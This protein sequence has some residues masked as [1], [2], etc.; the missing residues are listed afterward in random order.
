MPGNKKP[1]KK[2]RPK[3]NLQDPVGYLLEGLQ[4]I[5][6]KDSLL[7]DLQ[8]KNSAAMAAL[9]RGRANRKDMDILI[10]MSNMIDAL[11]GFG[12]GADY[13]EV[14]ISGRE[15]LIT[16]AHRSQ[17]VGKFGPSG[18]DIAALNALLE[19]HDAQMDVITVNDMQRAISQINTRLARGEATHLPGIT[20]GEIHV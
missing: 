15:A 19:L 14:A 9:T 5:R 1:H 10:A 7:V 8:L 18:T 17:R 3:A 6:S 2:Y 12:I 20:T 16:I 11:Q 4:T 13:R